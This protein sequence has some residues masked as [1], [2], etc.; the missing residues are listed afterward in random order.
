MFNT[1]TGKTVKISRLVKL[2]SD[3]LEDV[4][5]VFAGDIFATFGIDCATGDTFTS[6]NIY[7]HIFYVQIGDVMR[8][9]SNLYIIR[10]CKGSYNGVDA[11]PRPCYVVFNQSSKG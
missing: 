4:N 9:F 8:S 6:K 5:E 11:C 1:R 10:G 7:L 3:E 2:H